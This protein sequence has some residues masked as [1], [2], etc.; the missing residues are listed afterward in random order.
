MKNGHYEG[1]EER[2]PNFQRTRADDSFT[3]TQWQGMKYVFCCE[4]NEGGKGMGDL[5]QPGGEVE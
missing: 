1:E 3:E 5:A 2:R 4:G